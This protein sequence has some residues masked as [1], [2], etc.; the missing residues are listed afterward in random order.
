MCSDKR[1]IFVNV[2]KIFNAAMDGVRVAGVSILCRHIVRGPRQQPLGA[3]ADAR[4]S[5]L[6][7]STLSDRPDAAESLAI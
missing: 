3:G 5:I 1:L 4:E 6:R 7:R 2:N